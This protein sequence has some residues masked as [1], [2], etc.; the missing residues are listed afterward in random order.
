[1]A[2]SS[3]VRADMVRASWIRRMFEEGNRLRARHG[4]D[5][6]IDLSLGNPE[7]DPPPAFH[8]AL[9]AAVEE[10]AAPRSGL[11][12]YMPN[13]GYPETRAAVAARASEESG[14]AISADDVIMSCGAA[15][16]LNVVLKAVLDPGDEVAILE[17]FFPEYEF[18]V[19][20]HGGVPHVVS[21]AVDFS[22]DLGAI[23][24][25]LARP[26]SRIKA[27]LLSSPNNPTGRMYEAEEIDALADLLRRRAPHV[28]IV[29]DEPYRR[30]VFDG[31]QC[32]SVLGRYERTIFVGS[33]SKDLGIP[34]ERI[35]AIVL[36]PEIP[37]EERRELA[38]AMT[39]VTRTLG[40]VNAPALMQR[41]VRGLQGVTVS[42]A[43]YQERRDLLCDALARAGYW[44][45]RPQGAFY[46][47]PRTPEPDDVRFVERLARERLLL[48]VPGS[49]F[50]RA[51][52][53]RI[54][55]CVRRE[56]IE[57]ALPIFEAVAREYGL[58]TGGGAG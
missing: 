22:L 28:Y 58:G 54:S 46:L 55:F 45:V 6:V 2:I 30:L 7:I 37:L 35:G 20:N 31:R 17:P 33:H 25:A 26:E 51:G 32:P 1:M 24:R 18:Y 47:F 48:T 52:H 4:P 43:E 53:F 19:G 27:L 16:G 21:T 10:A 34:G 57:R 50:G 44:F 29:T 5:A 56:T 38:A 9:R 3:R 42:P 11:H 36:S 40:F 41:A 13:A 49:G 39:F 23:A 14:L 12:R 8:A 15:G